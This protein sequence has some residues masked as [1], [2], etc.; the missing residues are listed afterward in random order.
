M[1]RR[2]DPRRARAHLTYDAAEIS[3]TFEVTVG[4]VHGWRKWE[5]LTPIDGKR[6]YLFAGRELA[7]FLAAKNKPRQPLMPGHILCVACKAHRRPR[8]NVARVAPKTAT[9]VNLI[10][11]CPVCECDIYRRTRIAEL[12]EKAGSLHLQFED[13][14]VHLEEACRAPHTRALE[15]VDQ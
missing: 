12:R 11:Q 10:G 6:P 15:E 1:T 7:R 2:Y 5:G 13:G 4:T 8:G 3:A 9:S 14:T